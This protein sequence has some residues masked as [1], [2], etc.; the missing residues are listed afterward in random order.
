[1]SETFVLSKP[2]LHQISLAQS[3]DMMQLDRKNIIP[4]S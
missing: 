1:M 3:R 2:G 4:I